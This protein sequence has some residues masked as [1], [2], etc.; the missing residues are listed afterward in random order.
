MVLVTDS[1]DLLHISLDV[2]VVHALCRLVI[3]LLF[4]DTI[5]RARVAVILLVPSI[6]RQ[7][8]GYHNNSRVFDWQGYWVGT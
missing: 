8:G 5:D 4:A 1:R 7:S 3:L 2:S 6:V